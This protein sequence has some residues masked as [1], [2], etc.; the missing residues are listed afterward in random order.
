MPI[1][2][3]DIEIVVN[4]FASYLLHFEKTLKKISLWFVYGGYKIGPSRIDPTYKQVVMKMYIAIY[5]EIEGRHLHLANKSR[6]KRLISKRFKIIIASWQIEIGMPNP[7][8]LICYRLQNYGFIPC[9]YQWTNPTKQYDTFS[10]NNAYNPRKQT[11]PTTFYLHSICIYKF[12][13]AN[14]LRNSS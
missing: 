13:C 12:D 2:L 3:Q 9:F 11:C 5:L 4:I 10:S 14:C 8:P 7:Q 6:I 1:R